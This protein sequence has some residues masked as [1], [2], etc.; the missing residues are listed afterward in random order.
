MRKLTKLQAS[1]LGSICLVLLL[2]CTAAFVFFGRDNKQPFDKT[3]LSRVGFP[4]LYPE[5]IPP[6]YKL[7]A[8]SV[9]YSDGI[10]VFEFRK[11]T[12]LMTFTEQALPQKNLMLESI[13]GLNPVKTA[14][15]TAYIGK[16][17]AAP[18]A[19]ISGSRTLVN[20]SGDSSTPQ[21]VISQMAASLKELD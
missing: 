19:I 17:G 9:A 6:G 1:R 13:V 8:D 14:L 18:V 7:N 21:D 20:I 15:G 11:N 3:I 10:L 5:N 12:Q 16:A 2:L 4:I